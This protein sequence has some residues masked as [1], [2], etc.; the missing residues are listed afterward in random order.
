MH[1]CVRFL[2]VKQTATTSVRIWSPEFVVSLRSFGDRGRLCCIPLCSAAFDASCC[3]CK[4]CSVL[5]K[6][7]AWSLQVYNVFIKRISSR[8]TCPLTLSNRG[9]QVLGMNRKRCFISIRISAF[10]CGLT[11]SIAP[12]KWLCISRKK[13]KFLWTIRSCCLVDFEE[14][15][16]WFKVTFCNL[17]TICIS[18]YPTFLAREHHF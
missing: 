7:D 5:Q 9:P 1:L 10:G 3:F 8:G 14:S 12:S 2:Q 6:V 17:E 11:M 4:Q 18:F 15:N 16:V 13:S